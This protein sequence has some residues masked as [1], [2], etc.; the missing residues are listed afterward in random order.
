MKELLPLFAGPGCLLGTEPGSVYK[1]LSQVK[2]HLGLAFPDLYEVGMSYL[3]QKILYG[4]INALPQFY[5]ERVYAPTKEVAEVLTAHSTPLC[6]LESDTPLR[7]LDALAFHLTHELCYTNVLYMLE[8]GGIP[9]YSKERG[10]NYPLIIAGGGCTFNAEPVAPFFDV[11]IIGD[12]EE[13]VIDILHHIAKA[14]KT[15]LTREALL[16]EL[17]CLPG[18]YI[19]CFFQVKDQAVLPLVP[20]YDSVEK[21]LIPDLEKCPFPTDHVVPYA[22][23]IHDR[24][25]LEIARGCTRGCR[26]CQAGMIYRPVRERSPET[27]DNLA[28]TGLHN[29]GFGDLSFLSL[30]TGDYSALEELFKHSFTRCQ[31]EQISISLPS[32][33]VGSISENIMQLMTSIR[34]TGITLAPEAGSQ[35]LRD[36]INKGITEEALLSHVRRL[37]YHGWQQVKLYFMLGLPTETEEDLEAIKDLCLKVRDAAGAGVKRLQVTAAVSPFVPK[38]HTPFQWEA[39]LNMEEVQQRISFLHE[40][41]KPHKRIK[42]KWHQPEMSFL[43]GIFSRGGREL[44]PV[45]EQAYKDGATFASWSNHLTLAPW[46]TAMKDHGLY[47]KTYL[48]ARD[49]DVPLPWDH[50]LS[51]V[52]KKFLATEKSR[53]M[54]GKQTPDCRYNPCCHCGVCNHKGHVSTLTKQ[55]AEKNI[56]PQVIYTDRDQKALGQSPPLKK[57]YTAPA[58]KGKKSK[59]P[60]LGPLCHKACIY[61]VWHTKTDEMRFLSPLELQSLIERILRRGNIP[62]SFSAGFH[63]LPRVSFGKALSVGVAST[64]EWFNIVLRKHMSPQDLGKALHSHLPKGFHLKRIETLPLKKQHPQAVSE[65]FFLQFLSGTDKDECLLQWQKALKAK[66]LPFTKKTKKGTRTID[67]RPFITSATSEKDGLILHFNWQEQYISPLRLIM[68]INPNLSPHLFLLTKTK[69]HMA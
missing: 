41:L 11:M 50:L 38:P 14:K 25:A 22:G 6:T 39:Q 43:E 19:P 66:T 44:A 55:G 46:L 1:D 54:A 32:L 27:L 7:E 68:H 5:A 4:I 35:R 58:E 29:T 69:Q 48:A 62:V 13:I 28:E 21:A 56:A 20:G 30:S 47:P 61:R 17:A 45:V 60:D 18:V 63:P 36:V 34:R 31:K 8:L 51:G 37:F 67:I 42:L 15:G 3:G 12:G 53:A 26:F 33:R 23:I 24:M 2:A 40:L 10:A 64:C 65:E 52:T 16:K 57:E 49:E 59:P 9:L